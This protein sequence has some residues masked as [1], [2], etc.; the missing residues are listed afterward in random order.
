MK[1]VKKTCM[2]M[3]FSFSEP[4]CNYIEKKFFIEIMSD[5]DG[6]RIKDKILLEPKKKIK[7]L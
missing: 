1:T 6:Q 4:L 3:Y 2:Y 5:S 7:S